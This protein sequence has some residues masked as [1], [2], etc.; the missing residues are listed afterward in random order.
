VAILYIQKGIQVLTLQWR[1]SEASAYLSIVI[2][3]LVLAVG[4][5]ASLIGNS[6]LFNHPIRVF[7][8]DYGT[9]LAVVVFTG[10][11][12]IGRMDGVHLERM[13]ISK[14][15]LPTPDR[16]WFVRIWDISTGDIFLAIP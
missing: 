10:F 2:A 4:Y 12:F 6:N 13:P 11:Q 14:A 9:P 5:I 1:A 8:K 15:F 16:D 3:L 7:L